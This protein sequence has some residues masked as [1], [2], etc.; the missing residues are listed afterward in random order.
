M[1]EGDPKAPFQLLLHQGVGEGATPFFGL[2]H[3]T[4]DTYLIMLSIKQGG[5]KYHFF[6][7]FGMT[8]L[9][10]EPRS[11]VPLVNTL[12]T[13]PM[14]RLYSLLIN[15]SNFIV[16][17]KYLFAHNPILMI[18]KKINLTYIL[19]SNRYYHFRLEW[20]WE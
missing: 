20:T 14:S 2:L 19:D 4:L 7:V 9:G 15:P 16:S 17:N 13:R 5:I 10:I 6:Q 11:P 12:P 1:V 3:F 8:W 18:S